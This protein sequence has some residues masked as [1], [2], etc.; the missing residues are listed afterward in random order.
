MVEINR[1]LSDRHLLPF[2]KPALS[3]NTP[4]GSYPPDCSGKS[5]SEALPR[6]GNEVNQDWA[7]PPDLVRNLS[8]RFESYVSVTKFVSMEGAL[9]GDIM[10][11]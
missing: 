1:I 8:I 7:L 4:L 9:Y 2:S 5:K 10:N 3:G 6:P 11:S